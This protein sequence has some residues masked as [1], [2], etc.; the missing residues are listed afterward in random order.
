[1]VDFTGGIAE[2]VNFERD[3]QYWMEAVR[4]ELYG[5]LMTAFSKRSL[6]TAGTESVRM[7]LYLLIN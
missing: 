1:M 5:S 7:L 3:G 4:E 2:T 6:I